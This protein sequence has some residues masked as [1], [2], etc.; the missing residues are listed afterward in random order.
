MASDSAYLPTPA[1][2]HDFAGPSR[3]ADVLDF[4]GEVGGAAGV[5]VEH[6]GVSQEGRPL[7]LVTLGPPGGLGVFLLARQHGDEPAG[8]EALLRLARDLALGP[9]RSLLASLRVTLLPLMNP[10]GAAR[11][12]RESASG[13][14]LNRNHT[15]L[16]A[17]ELRALHREFHRRR[18]A[19][20]VDLHKY[21]QDQAA[22]RARGFRR[23]GDLLI[24][25]ATH[26]N[27]AQRLRDLAE[28]FVPRMGTALES[29]GLTFGRY[30][31]DGPPPP[32]DA[33]QHPPRL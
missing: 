15:R 20:T 7:P 32:A 6:A 17:P 13:E 8:T 26:L 9:M 4:L 14:N 30:L 33:H 25:S 21:T 24:G 5:R 1:E 16:T 29:A 19:V 23:A 3:A 10:D 31:L 27:V 12:S 11:N 18:P 2:G 28:A 22:W